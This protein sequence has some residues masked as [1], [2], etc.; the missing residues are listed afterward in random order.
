[1]NSCKVVSAA[2]YRNLGARAP[3]DPLDF[4]VFVLMALAGLQW[5]GFFVCASYLGFSPFSGI[6][7]TAYCLLF[8]SAC[9]RL[10]FH[11]TLRE[12]YAAPFLWWQIFFVLM[13]IRCERPHLPKLFLFAITTCLFMLTWQFAQFILLLQLAA[14]YA[15]YALG[16]L[17]RN[18]FLS[19]I[20]G[21]LLAG[22]VVIVV[23]L[24]NTMLLT[25]MHLIL[26]LTLLLV[27][28]TDQP[29]STF[30]ARVMHGL[31]AGLLMIVA[32]LLAGVLADDDAHIFRILRAKFFNYEDFITYLY[33][34]GPTYRAME[35]G[36][37]GSFFETGLLHL[38]IGVAASIVRMRKGGGETKL[39]LM[40][41]F[42][43]SFYV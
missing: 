41:H 43:S 10:N 13:N 3:K 32:K 1:M 34:C 29:R 42:L 28:S 38:A 35:W 16:F 20:K 6:V 15:S 12:N 36:E 30:S 18:I 39:D 33:L 17:N 24:G 26:S 25:S 31:G 40:L 14:L 4:T 11:L 21:Y 37:F 23:T 8:V 2:V 7:S 22:A 9:S 5:A 19:V 27:I